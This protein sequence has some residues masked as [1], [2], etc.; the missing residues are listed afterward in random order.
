MPRF[1]WLHIKTLRQRTWFIPKSRSS[2]CERWKF[3]ASTSLGKVPVAQLTSCYLGAHLLLQD[4]DLIALPRTVR[5][6]PRVLIPIKQ[7][8]GA[9]CPESLF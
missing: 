4:K 1:R 7:G 5:L 6:K 8:T 2:N 9:A 3:R